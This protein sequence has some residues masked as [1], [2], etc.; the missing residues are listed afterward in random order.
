MVYRIAYLT[1][2]VLALHFN[3]LGR[4][5]D[6]FGLQVWFLRLGVP[7]S[8]RMHTSP[9]TLSAGQYTIIGLWRTNAHL[10]TTL[11]ARGREGEGG[12]AMYSNPLYV[13]LLVRNAHY[14][15]GKRWG[16]AP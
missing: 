13:L 16:A 2:G 11:G 5:R 9:S 10:K 8:V 1:I 15:Y 4:W 14:E 3:Q 7:H 12:V 6:S